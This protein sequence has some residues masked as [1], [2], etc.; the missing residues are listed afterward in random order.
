MSTK[1]EVGS[2]NET[3]LRKLE[4]NIEEFKAVDKAPMSKRGF[5]LSMEEARQK[6]DRSTIAEYILKLKPKAQV[7]LIKNLPDFGLVNGS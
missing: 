1:V 6:L 3:Q 2:I 7:M 5:S 4:G